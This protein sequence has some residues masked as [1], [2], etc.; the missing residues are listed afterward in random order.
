MHC[1]NHSGNTPLHLACMYGHIDVVKYLV[2]E[3]EYDVKH[4]NGKGFSAL[5]CAC[6]CLKP[7]LRNGNNLDVVKYLV[8]EENIDPILS[9]SAGITP[10]H[11]A[12][13]YG[14][15]QIVQYLTEE[16]HCD[17]TM[18]MNSGI[19]S[20]LLA[21]SSGVLELVKYFIK[22]LGPSILAACNQRNGRTAFH[23]ACRF[24]CITVAKYLVNKNSNP[25]LKDKDGMTPL[26]HA[27]SC[28]TSVA[29]KAALVGQNKHMEVIRFLVEECNSSL[30]TTSNTGCT[31]LHV[32]SGQENLAVIKHLVQHYKC[33][34]SVTNNH[35][36]TALHIACRA[37]VS[38]KIIEYLVKEG[39][40][41]PCT[42]GKDGMAALHIACS[43]RNLEIVQFLVEACPCSFR[44]QSDDKT[45]PLG[46]ANSSGHTHIQ[47][48]LISYHKGK[49]TVEHSPYQL[50][51]HLEK[52]ANVAIQLLADECVPTVEY[53]NKWRDT[54]LHLACL[55]GDEE[56]VMYLI[57][58][59]KYKT[60]VINI[61]GDSALNMA[62]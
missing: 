55:Y 12:S 38:L 23:Y 28:K 10:L 56:I 1:S 58:D 24:G 40:C 39:Q 2:K 57:E 16:K 36:D 5:H 61:E 6:L 17:L 25:N 21:C 7:P 54:L 13:L 8:E 3:H 4:E 15:L 18:E 27:C 20:F 9:N 33:N 48:Y 26:H 14:G 52:D 62:C 35:G 22:V 42:K 45:T 31:P 50:E 30:E 29:W 19:T 53:Y 32:A 59:K 41:D 37:G 47:K 60:T 49:P 51:S 11:L 43:Y 46:E 44:T 34:P